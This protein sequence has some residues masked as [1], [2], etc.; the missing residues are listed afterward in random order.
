MAWGI[1]NKIR[2]GAVKAYN[3]VVPIAQKAVEIAKKTVDYAKPLLEGTKYAKYA[4][5]AD[6]VVKKGGKVVKNTS[7]YGDMLG[8]TKKTIK[9]SIRR[10]IEALEFDDDANDDEF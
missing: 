5:V 8:I 7:D 4:E 2:D 10:Q 3:T 6:E 9:P 1:F